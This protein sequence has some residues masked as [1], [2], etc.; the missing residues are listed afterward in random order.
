MENSSKRS[1]SQS[2]SRIATAKSTT[3][4]SPEPKPPFVAPNNHSSSLSLPRINELEHESLSVWKEQPL[5]NIHKVRWSIA[6][7]CLLA[8]HECKEILYVCI[9]PGCAETTRLACEAC[10]F[11]GHSVHQEEFLALDEIRNASFDKLRFWAFDK[12]FKPIHE[13]VRTHENY[14]SNLV[15][16][17]NA[18]FDTMTRNILTEINRLKLDLLRQVDTFYVTE[19]KKKLFVDELER[20]LE[21]C[22]ELRKIRRTVSKL[23]SKE[24]KHSVWMAEMGRLL[25]S[26]RTARAREKL[27][28]YFANADK[29]KDMVF[30]KNAFL[31]KE[32]WVIQQV[33]EQKET[34]EIK[35]VKTFSEVALDQLLPHTLTYLETAAK[36]FE[37]RLCFRTVVYEDGSSYVGFICE[38]KREV[39][40]VRYYK[41]GTRYLGEWRANSRA[42]W[43]TLLND[44]SGF[45]YAGEWR[46]D[47]R[48]GY[49]LEQTFTSTYEGQ[50][51]HD[52][53]E[54]FGVLVEGGS[55]LEISWKNDKKHGKGKV[56]QANGDEIDVYYLNGIEAPAGK[57]GSS[58]SAVPDLKELSKRFSKK[59]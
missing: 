41:N 29:G 37:N 36:P 28:H 51:K 10:F 38:E 44:K 6:P 55:R 26:D 7:R 17:I 30:D 19:T 43:G 34:L 46:E 12:R 5:P 2:T 22:F 23:L 56:I 53:K 31:R 15:Q 32:N 9:S 35:D 49:G 3:K 14:V 39:V 58:G 11:G 27:Q 13:F 42:G 20:E 48:N 47:R 59:S 21:Q 1:S 33:R 45:R 54:G 24:V 40:G 18:T 25:N 52:K 16:D 8:E 4:V 50:F 57:S